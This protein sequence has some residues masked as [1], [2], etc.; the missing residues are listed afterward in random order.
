[1]YQ[2]AFDALGKM[3]LKRPDAKVYLACLKAP[4]GLFVHEIVTSTKI[5]RSTVDLILRRLTAKNILS[6]FREGQRRKFTATAPEKILFAFQREMEDFK[7]VLPLLARLGNE[8]DQTRVTFHEGVPGLRTLFDEIILTLQDLPLP[9]RVLHCITSN[10]EIER[11]NPRF[12][13]QFIDRRV[14]NRIRVEM[15]AQRGTPTETWASSTRDLRITKMFDGQKY[16]LGMEVDVVHDRLILMSFR[17][18][19]GGLVVR[20]RVLAASMRSIFRLVWDLLGPPEPDS[21]AK[22]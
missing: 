18:P 3:G 22:A 5:K 17:K 9:E 14:Q 6:S 19:V 16:P 13:K 15:I 4:A 2:D 7:A 11:L 21:D 1:M 20:N 8:D 10:R 12:R